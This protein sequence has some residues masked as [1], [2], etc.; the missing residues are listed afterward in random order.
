[1]YLQRM[2][3]QSV[4]KA[5][6]IITIS[7]FT[8]NDIIKTFNTN[9]DKISVIYEGIDKKKYQKRSNSKE[10]EIVK[11]KY[12]LSD[13][14][15]LS[16][17]HLEPR[18]NYLRLIKAFELLKR[19]HHIP[20]KLIIIG[21]EN[22]KFKEIFEL[23]EELGL[24]EHI[25]ITGFVSEGD[26][27]SIYQ[28]A[29]VFVTASI[30]EGFGFTPLEAMA[31]SVPVAASNATSIPEVVGDAANLFDPLDVDDIAAN[32]YEVICNTQL[33]KELV[34]KGYKNLKRFDWN[35]CC[36]QTVD[37]YENVLRMLK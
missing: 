8:K 27:I 22:W 32:I 17:G 26:L 16:V 13:K 12:G 28:N 36:S 2:I 18:K 31:A 23:I 11:K 19:K 4:K 29:D 6:R 20:H 35:E 5:I 21:R 34:Q 9:P 14:Y 30:F 25:E 10:F 3:S 15:I 1:M 37:E 24:S 33:R 7:E